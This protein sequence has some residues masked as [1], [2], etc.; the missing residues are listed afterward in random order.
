MQSINAQPS[1]QQNLMIKDICQTLDIEWLS[2]Q[3]VF[4]SGVD[5]ALE[6][7]VSRVAQAVV[8]V[9]DVVHSNA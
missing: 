9:S 6:K 5:D 7:A 4:R 1:L 8:R 3:L 2:G